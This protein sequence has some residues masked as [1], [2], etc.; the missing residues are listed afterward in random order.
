MTKKTK[1]Q[2]K[3]LEHLRNLMVLYQQEPEDLTEDELDLLKEEGW[4]NE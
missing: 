4:I 3:H 2:E 1:Q